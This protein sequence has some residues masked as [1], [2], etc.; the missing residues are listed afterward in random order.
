MAVKLSVSVKPSA[1]QE[2]VDQL[3]AAEYVVW[4]RAPAREG[5]ANEAVVA[6]LAKHLAVPKSSL[7][8]VRGE[9]ARKK[10]IE[11]A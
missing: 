7:R 2:K 6:L 11:I 10:I 1:R 3:S 5:R 9:K 4:V 8:V